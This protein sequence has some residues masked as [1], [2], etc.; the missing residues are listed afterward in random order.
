AR[1][2]RVAWRMRA[3]GGDLVLL[4]QAHSRDPVA[5]RSTGYGSGATP[6]EERLVGTFVARFPAGDLAP[7]AATLRTGA[8]A[9]DFAWLPGA[10]ELLVA[11]ATSGA[12]GA[13][14]L[15]RHALPG[16]AHHRGPCQPQLGRED[17]FGAASAVEAF[18]YVGT[19]AFV[20]LQPF[21]GML[22]LFTPGRHAS[23]V[24]GSPPYDT[25]RDIFHSDPGGGLACASCHPEGGED[26]HVWSLGDGPRRTQTLRG[27]IME[28][29]P[30]HWDGRVRGLGA[31]MSD[32]FVNRMNGPVLTAEQVDALGQ[33]LD[34]LPAVVPE[35][36]DLEAVA[37]GAQVFADQ[38]CAGCHAGDD[39]TQADNVG[40]GGRLLQVPFLV[41]LATRAPYFHDGC[42]ATLDAVLEP[43]GE[44]LRVEHEV[45]AQLT[46]AARADLV[47]YLS[48][49]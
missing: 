12:H 38:G 41:G 21:S 11:E 22:R 14:Q 30:F 45:G 43:C 28:T 26:A 42:A 34:E 9:V 35:A 4:G 13:P 39:G 49:R 44:G 25:A 18:P 8:L 1:A 2:A 36:R 17:V 23:V 33:Y 27:G 29:L 5:V 6:C 16:P 46:A 40:V 3:L 37:R 48:S 47:A 19:H 10:G 31:V 15:S 24:L 32:T 20:V 7:T